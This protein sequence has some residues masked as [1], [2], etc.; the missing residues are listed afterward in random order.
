MA[1]SA[2]HSRR[3]CQKGLHNGPRSRRPTGTRPQTVWERLRPLRLAVVEQ[4]GRNDR[5]G[6]PRCLLVVG[7]VRQ[8]DRRHSESRY[9]R[10]AGRQIV[11]AGSGRRSLRRPEAVSAADRRF[12]KRREDREMGPHRR[13]CRRRCRDAQSRQRGELPSAATAALSAQSG[14]RV[15]HLGA[16]FEHHS[17]GA[18]KRQLADHV[19][20]RRLLVHGLRRR[21]RFRTEGEQEAEPR[22]GPRGRLSP[23]HPRREHSRPLRRADRQRR[24]RQKSERHADGRRRLVHVGPQCRQRATGPLGRSGQNVAMEP[25]AVRNGLCSADV[26]QLR[27]QLRRRTR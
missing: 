4:C 12:G 18:R 9:R 20:R 7:T 1:R 10:F 11:E 8:S 14:H 16:G 26:P 5:G 21:P 13:A 25:V 27:P 23:Q 19:G 24:S 22:F 15:H 2:N 3:F 17:Y 6:S